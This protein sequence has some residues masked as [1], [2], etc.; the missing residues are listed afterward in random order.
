M[1]VEMGIGIGYG[2]THRSTEGTTRNGQFDAL[3][4]REAIDAA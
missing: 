2:I 4:G 3:V 1:H